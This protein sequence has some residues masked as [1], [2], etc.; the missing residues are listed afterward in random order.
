MNEHTPGA[1]RAAEIITGGEY[2][3][4]G[5][6]MFTCASCGCTIDTKHGCKNVEGIADLIDSETSAPSMLAV[7]RE[8]VADCEAVDINHVIEHEEHGGMGWPDLGETYQKACAVIARV[9][10]EDQ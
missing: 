8:F 7:L 4:G 10:G 9:Q 3:S 6:Q 5:S 2:V 1:I